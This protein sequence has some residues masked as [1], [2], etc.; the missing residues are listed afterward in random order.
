MHQNIILISECDSSA[1]KNNPSTLYIPA[2]TCCK[3]DQSEAF[4][5]STPKKKS[6]NRLTKYYLLILP[7]FKNN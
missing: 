5:K 1:N 4:L 6:I 7:N 3:E 2:A